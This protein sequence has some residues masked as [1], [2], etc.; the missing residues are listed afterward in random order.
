MA[1]EAHE[2]RCQLVVFPELNLL[3]YHPCD[4]MERPTVIK[5]QQLAIQE[6]LKRLPKTLHCL[7]GAAT[8]NPGKGKPYFNS[9]LLIHQSQIKQVASKELLP[10]YDVF[11]DSRHFSPGKIKDNVFIIGGKRI[12]LLIC[13]DMWGW[14]PLHETNPILQI[15]PQSIDLVV[16]MS[17]SPFTLQKRAQR[18]QHARSTVKHLKAPLVYVNMTGAQDELIY[19]GG[20]FALSSEG[21]VLAQSAYCVEDLNLVD[22]AASEGGTRQVAADNTTHLYQAL[23]LGVQDFIRKVGFTKA[24]VGLSGGID[25]AVVACLVADAIGPQNLTAIAMPS[26]FNSPASSE[27]AATLAKNLGCHFYKLPIQ[28]SFESVV[29][30]YTQCFGEK[31][32]SLVHENFQ[33]RLRGVFLMGFANEHSSLLISAGNKSEYATGYSTLYGDMCG[34]LA[35][36]ADLLKSQVYEIAHFYNRE[37]ELIPSEIITRPPSAELRPNQKD[38]DSLPDYDMLDLSVDSLVSQKQ[39]AKTELDEWVL[40]KLYFSEFKRWQSPPILKVSDHAFGQGRRMPIAHRA[41]Y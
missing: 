35:P 29:E 15:E 34:G 3:G 19:D 32:F 39:K 16:N 28:Q 24:H 22:I 25:S 12:Q 23:V 21:E 2:K 1:E 11:D 14:D 36:I 31:E 7:V 9:A 8:A 17:A 26:Q 41:H 27:L 33:A 38:S 40:Q 13:E 4:L 20:S 37:R 30:S 6:L 18:L 10:V 5:S